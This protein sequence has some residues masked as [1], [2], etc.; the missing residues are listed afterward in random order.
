MSADLT[1]C[2]P[3][4]PGTQDDAELAFRAFQ[5]DQTW[6]HSYWEEPRAVGPDF[7]RLSA[8]A[9]GLVVPFACSLL[10]ALRKGVGYISASPTREPTPIRNIS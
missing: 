9:R 3:Q 2:R 7:T 1:D 6:Y 4:R 8:V 5:I 10:S